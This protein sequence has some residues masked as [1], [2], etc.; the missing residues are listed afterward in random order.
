MLGGLPDPRF[1]AA[2]SSVEDILG[3][4]SGISARLVEED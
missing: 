4:L 1:V 2:I 3:N